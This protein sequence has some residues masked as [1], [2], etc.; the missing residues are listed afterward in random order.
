MLCRFFIKESRSFKEVKDS[1]GSK[2]SKDSKDIKDSKVVKITKA[3]E[4]P[5]EDDIHDTFKLGFRLSVNILYLCTY[6]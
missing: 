6:V 1:R 3:L 4:K 5:K 2:D